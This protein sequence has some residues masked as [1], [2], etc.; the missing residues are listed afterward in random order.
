[1]QC[2]ATFSDTEKGGKEKKTKSAHLYI[3]D[4]VTMRRLAP[5]HRR[6]E[7]DKLLAHPKA[8]EQV[9]RLALPH[10]FVL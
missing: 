1:V 6:Q 3:I 2:G 9:R 4:T 7:I 5:D 8:K 10:L